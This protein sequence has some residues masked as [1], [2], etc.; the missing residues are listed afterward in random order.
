M[1]RYATTICLIIFALFWLLCHP[2]VYMEKQE[3]HT[4]G[5]NRPE[6]KV[7]VQHGTKLTVLGNVDKH[8]SVNE[9]CFSHTTLSI[10]LEAVYITWLTL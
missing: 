7:K 9:S 1:N 2:N 10:L 4:S 8:S 3:Y 5:K 6:L